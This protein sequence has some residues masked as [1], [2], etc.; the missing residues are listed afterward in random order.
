MLTCMCNNFTSPSK[1]FSS[2][3]A[4]LILYICPIFYRKCHKSQSLRNASFPWYFPLS[5]LLCRI[6]VVLFHLMVYP[7]RKTAFWVVDRKSWFW[8]TLETTLISRQLMASTSISELKW[9]QPWFQSTVLTTLE[10]NLILKES[11]ELN[12]VS[13]VDFKTKQFLCTLK[14]RL[15]SKGNLNISDVNNFTPFLQ[16]LTREIW[17]RYEY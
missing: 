17:R 12:L 9:S 10:T 2:W 7:Y 8:R 15:I 3:T 6:S 13:K 14:S 11:H 1:F 5:N 4:R 16:C